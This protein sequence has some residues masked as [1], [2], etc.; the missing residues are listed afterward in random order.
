[1]DGIGVGINS[2]VCPTPFHSGPMADLV[3]VAQCKWRWSAGSSPDC[4]LVH[5]QSDRE[6]HCDC[7]P[8]RIAL[9]WRSRV[10]SCWDR[11]LQ[12]R[13]CGTRAP[14]PVDTNPDH[15]QLTTLHVLQRRLSPS[16]L[17]LRIQ[18]CVTIQNTGVL[19]GLEPGWFS[20]R[21]HSPPRGLVGAWSR[22][23]PV[24]RSTRSIQTFNDASSR[25][26][27]SCRRARPDVNFVNFDLKNLKGGI[28]GGLTSMVVGHNRATTRSRVGVGPVC[29]CHK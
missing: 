6:R 3:R 24:A 23:A 22:S 13:S 16:S 14:H 12:S 5:L 2:R 25:R 26:L 4:A 18:A 17:F 8:R 9:K 20:G 29:A 28:F 7:M 1:M 15:G 10:G 27:L 11:S 21:V 19:S